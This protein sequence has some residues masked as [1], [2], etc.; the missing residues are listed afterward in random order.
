MLSLME[1]YLFSCLIFSFSFFFS[2]KLHE[3]KPKHVIVKMYSTILHDFR[4]GNSGFIYMVIFLLLLMASRL[5]R[6]K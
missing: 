4:G 1:V 2:G 6:E 5:K 3:K